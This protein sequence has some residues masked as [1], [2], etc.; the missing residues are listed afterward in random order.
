MDQIVVHYMQPHAP[1]FDHAELY[2][3]YDQGFG[4]GGTPDQSKDVWDQIRYGDASRKEIWTAYRHN[5]EVL[6]EE[7]DL[8]KRSCDADIVLTSDHGNGLGESGVYGH[9]RGIP[10]GEVRNVPWVRIDGKG[11]SD[12]TPKEDFAERSHSANARDRLSALGYK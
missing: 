12:Y 2:D 4:D 6:L 11:N 10:T 8:L 5:L 9:P 7:V 1:F 3:G